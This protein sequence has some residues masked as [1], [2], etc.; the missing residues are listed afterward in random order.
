MLLSSF[1]ISFPLSEPTRLTG[2][3]KSAGVFYNILFYVRFL[4]FSISHEPFYCSVEKEW[5]NDHV[6]AY[7]CH[8]R[9]WRVFPP[10][11]NILLH[12]QHHNH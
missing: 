12:C 3:G 2:K 8:V 7:K 6:F 4:H 11:Y 9:T 1:L 5:E 10:F